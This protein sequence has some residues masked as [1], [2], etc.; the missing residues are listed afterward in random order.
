[1]GIT[2]LSAEF[3]IQE[4]RYKPLPET[5]HLLGRQTICFD[6]ETARRMMLKHGITPVDVQRKADET[7]R[8]AITGTGQYIS[9]STF[10]EM[11]GVKTV[12][13]IDHSDYEGAEIIINLNRPI[14]PKFEGFADF[15][16]G[17]S[18]LDNVFDPACYMRNITRMLR[19]G[20]RLVDINSSSFGEHPYVL[21]SPAWYYDYCVINN[22]AACSLYV[23]EGGP[24]LSMTG[25]HIYNLD[26]KVE[27]E[28]IPDPGDPASG[29]RT[30][31]IM[32][33]EKGE[34]TSWEQSPSQDQYRGGEEWALYRRNLGRMNASP[35]PKFTARRPTSTEASGYAARNIRGL[36]H[37]GLFDAFSAN[38]PRQ[39]TPPAPDD[40]ERGIR[41][42]EATYGW[43]Q[44][45]AVMP[46][47]ANVPFRRGNVTAVLAMLV[48]GQQECDIGLDV[49]TLGDPAPGLPKDL[50]VL[51]YDAGE[52]NPRLH[53]LH[54]AEEAHGKRL[55]ISLKP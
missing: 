22:F 7:T 40:T 2:I 13:A 46:R 29:M 26:V 45:A 42:V 33:A 19:P 4:H 17:G 31:V 11:L 55:Q 48:N 52:A 39:A 50:T 47:I 9:D 44:R 16:F 21:I 32:I 14:E 27:D 20:G 15:I 8:T 1:M 49:T 18:V 28:T 53:R 12:H 30:H 38:P 23:S 5:V 34:Q 3:I 41:I 43:N 37:L 25:S 36:D 54:I 51:Y 10:F 6:F 35:R 24:A